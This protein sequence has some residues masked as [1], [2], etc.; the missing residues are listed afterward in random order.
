M[1]ATLIEDIAVTKNAPRNIRKTVLANGLMVL[2]ESMPHV[3]SV[4]M[5]AWVGSGSR[6]EKPELNGISHF[7][8][9]MVFKGTTSRSAQQIAREVDTIGGNLDAFTGKETVCFNIKVLDENVT[10]ALDVLA[11][12]VLHPT[13]TPEDVAR[14]Q[15]VILEE[16]K[17]DEDNPDYLVHETWTQNFWKGDA[18]GRPILGTVK[19]VSSFDQQ[20][21]FDFYAG[22]FT[23]RNMVFSA[24]GNLQHDE[25]VAKVEREF[26]SLAASGDGVAEKVAAPKATPHITLKRKKSLEQVQFCLGVPAPRVNDARRYGVYLLNTMLGGGMSSRLFQTIREDRGL[27]YSIYSEMNPFRDTGSLCVYAGTSVDKTLQVLELT[28]LELRRLKEEKVSEVELKRAK[29]QLK[30]NMVIGL[31]SSGSRMSNLARQQMY[32]GRF[33]GVDE[34]IE[35]VDA[36]SSEDVQVLAQELFQPETMAL[37]LLGNLGT[38]K[39][40]REDLA[41]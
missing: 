14:E 10:P 7:V 9:H 16:I 35:E 11:D 8:E 23:P 17:M 24:A 15:G 27:A 1:S 13:F 20:K 12:L 40:E 26:S 5:G 33:F 28:L 39:V 41:C 38:M 21:L 31:E 4:S 19:T 18:L 6:D 36:V 29:D 22:Q 30:S 2:T 37:T 32:F 3:R 25:F 34:I